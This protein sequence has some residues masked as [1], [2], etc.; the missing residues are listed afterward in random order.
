MYVLFCVL[1]IRIYFVRILHN[2]F[3]DNLMQ[4]ALLLYG[5][6][7]ILILCFLDRCSSSLIFSICDLIVFSHKITF[8]SIVELI[9]HMNY[10]H[11]LTWRPL[12]SNSDNHL[13]K[14]KLLFAL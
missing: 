9:C 2:I 12:Q 5:I 3:V 8:S 6:P 4:S 10:Y 1:S 13:T 14:T 11:T 7:T